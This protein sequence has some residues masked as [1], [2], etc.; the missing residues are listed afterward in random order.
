MVPVAGRL[1]ALT[2]F[3]HNYERVC[4]QNPKEAERSVL[5]VIFYSRSNE[6]DPSRE[7]L[8][9]LRDRYGPQRVRILEGHGNFSRARALDQGAKTLGERDLMFFIDVDIHFGAGALL[10]LRRNC[11][12]GHRMYFPVVFSQYDPSVVGSD[13]GIISERTGFW[14]IF[15]FGIAAMYRRDYNS[16]G[17]FDLGI[18]GWGKEDVD[19]FEKVVRSELEVFR[20][21]DVDLV[22]IYHGVFCQSTLESL[23]YSMCKGTRADT[24]AG[25]Q[26]LGQMIYD[27]PA[28]LRFARA[29][30]I[31]ANANASSAPAG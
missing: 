26:Q 18:E 30:R 5:M 6:P 7:I 19:L 13:N 8:V 27:N 1:E 29:R 4:L 10:R 21:P 16:V 31:A 2:R 14:R 11:I 12:L 28:Y 15:G 23:Q 17:G 25:T 24:Y 20:A 22:H 9:Q 3:V